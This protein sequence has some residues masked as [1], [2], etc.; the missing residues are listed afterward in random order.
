MRIE[1]LQNPTQAP[2]LRAWSR[3]RLKFRIESERISLL[4]TK[5]ERKKERKKREGKVPKEE[6]AKVEKEREIIPFT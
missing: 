6:K 5:K 4:K 2:L 3:N 1:S